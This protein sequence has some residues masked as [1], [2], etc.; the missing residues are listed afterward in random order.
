MFSQNG[1]T[2]SN[3]LNKIFISYIWVKIY[4]LICD[5]KSDSSQKETSMF[6]K[7]V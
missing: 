7:N 6:V 2:V 1:D 4:M 5:D 3:K